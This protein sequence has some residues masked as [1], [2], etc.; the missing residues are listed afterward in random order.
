[1]G[2]TNTDA[3]LVE[4]DR[5]VRSVKAATT[6]D[7]T[8]GI[9]YALERLLA[10]PGA[11]RDDVDA[12]MIGTTHFTNAVVQRR[13]LS[14]VAAIRIGLPASA[15]LPPF[16]DWPPDLAEIVRGEVVMLEGGHEYDGRPLVPFDVAGMRAAAKRIRAA[17]LRA[18]AVAAIFSPLNAAC[19]AAAAEILREECPD[20]HV[21]L[22][23]CLGQIG[24]LERENAA[25]LNAAL[26]ELAHRTAAAFTGALRDSGLAAPLFMTQNDGT[27]SRANEALAFPVYGFAS[28]PTNSMRGAAFLSGRA[29]AMVVDVGGTTT[30]IGSLRHG[31]PRQ[32]NNVV[33]VGGVRTLFRMPDLLSL[34]LGGGSLVGEDPLAVG[35]LSVGYRLT[36]RARV[37]GGPDLTVTD[38]GV[39]A[40]LI[41]LGERRRVAGLPPRLIEAALRRVHTMID[42][43]VDRMKT[44]AGDVPLVAVGGGCFLVPAKLPGVSEIVHVPHREVANAVGAAIA[45]VSGEA[46]Q[47]FQGLSRDEAIGEAERLARAKATGAG[48]DPATI[49]VVEVEDLPIAYLPGN[50]LRVRVRVVGAVEPSRRD[51]AGA[52]A[53]REP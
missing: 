37:F 13:D 43:G 9:V 12:V 21:T 24:L 5:V 27:V 14:R 22:S 49:E 42:E 19:E 46:D 11:A 53:R 16:V 25:I 10:E 32:A 28:G 52:K 15:S 48:A 41:E 23:H 35:P 39:A 2:G 26:V 34:G 45:Q 50:S 47:I 7:V 40:G 20:V 3:V 18:V 30:D 36:E 31:F 44:E 6:E 29:D 17:G 8:R 4:G 33:E 1:V 38:V 51:A